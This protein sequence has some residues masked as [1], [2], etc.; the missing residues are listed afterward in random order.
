MVSL[1]SNSCCLISLVAN[2]VSQAI[3]LYL[4]NWEGW[5]LVNIYDGLKVVLCKNCQIEACQTA[6]PS[7]CTT[8]W[9]NVS[10]AL[11]LSKL[12]EL[13]NI[14]YLLKWLV[15]RCRCII[16]ALFPNIFPFPCLCFMHVLGDVG[17]KLRAHLLCHLTSFCIAA[18]VIKLLQIISVKCF[19]SMPL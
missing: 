9:L 17:T 12:V 13:S 11:L 7:G 10:R 8:E 1:W 2:R 14:S 15:G 19:F 6:V 3:E 16:N 5:C 4:W 18:G